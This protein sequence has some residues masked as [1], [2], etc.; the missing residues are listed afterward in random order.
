MYLEYPEAMMECSD[1][2]N[3]LEP[4]KA[5]SWLKGKVSASD[6]NDESGTII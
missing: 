4:W 6:N 5:W 3:M 1:D 2:S